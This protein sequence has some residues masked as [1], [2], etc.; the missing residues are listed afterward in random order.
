MVWE[1]EADKEIDK[2]EVA[3]EMVSVKEGVVVMEVDL[4][5]EVDMVMEAEKEVDTAMVEIQAKV[6]V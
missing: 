6:V 1:T 5:K 4:V 3:M 2:K